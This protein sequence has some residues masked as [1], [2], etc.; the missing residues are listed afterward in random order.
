M[1][2]ECVTASSNISDENRHF[3]RSFALFEFHWKMQ[4][5]LHHFI[6]L[7]L[8]MAFSCLNESASSQCAVPISSFPYTEGFETNN[9]NW[10]RSSN[11]HWE[12]G[13][14][15]PGSKAVITSAGGGQKC[16]IVGGLSGAF[17]NSGNSYLISP[18]FDFTTLANPEIGFKI[19]WET[20]ANFDG[21]NLQYSTDE[22]AS[23]VRVGSEISNS[24]C[25][26]TNW[27]NN[28]SVRF[29][30]FVPGWSGNV[31]P[32]GSGSCNN[33]SGSG[34][35]LFAK[36][37]LGFLSG[38]SKVIFRF[39]FGA[40]I[41]CNDYEGLAIDDVQI[42]EAPPEGA[43]FEQTCLSSQTIRFTDN[44]TGCVT[45][46]LWDF[47]DTASG[48]NNSSTQSSP[49]HI[50][51]G[52][53]TFTV[54]LTAIF[55]SGPP[56]VSTRQVT[57][58]S[59]DP[60]VVN[61]IRCNGDNN[62][63]IS[64]NVSG[65]SGIYSYTWNTSPPQTTASI[66][67]LSGNTY[68]VLVAATNSCEFSSSITLVEPPRLSIITAFSPATCGLSNGSV[69]ATVTGGTSSYLYLW[70]NSEMTNV[71][72][73][74][75]PG[76]YSLQVTDANGCTATTPAIQ[77]QNQVIPANVN[78]GGDTTICPG[79]VLILKPGSFVSY[80]WQDNSSSP[81][82]SVTQSGDYYVT[83]LNS[84]GC[85]GSDSIKVTVECKGVY[86]PSSFSPNNDGINETFGPVGDIGM[87]RD[88]QMTIYNRW[89]QVVFVSVNPF[90][91]WDGK[92]K[93]ANADLQSF[94][95]KATY[96]M[97]GEKILYKKGTV[98]MIR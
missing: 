16:W 65:G 3:G 98:T 50:F 92:F 8:F 55:S 48:A 44:S 94:V 15:V 66:N 87:I 35:W 40:G 45:G 41:I 67:N 25:T 52:P 10:T 61:P 11:Q 7:F 95:W 64:V 74:L 62:G 88:F 71:I 81:S 38:Q 73:D 80:T 51:S 86:F 22:G 77:I 78:F 9:G 58:L 12:W 76:N 42:I 53:G 30:G 75:A 5:N 23:W 13:S 27:Y 97:N 60:F 47:G 46:L 34:S 57:V 39:E 84:A 37:N 96:R 72:R 6:R 54:T 89:G 69:S 33:G 1:C 36:H 18:C 32:G 91:K 43:Y 24:N 2:L 70:S 56:A 31:Q 28:A 17:Y 85:T 29:L 21:V 14:I 49:V 4:L 20:E 90:V 79:Q 68:T 93:G 83:V 63:G 26:G 59:L 19:I 82:F